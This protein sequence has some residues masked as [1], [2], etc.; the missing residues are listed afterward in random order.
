[1]S[2]QKG[3]DL[4]LNIGDGAA[5]EVYTTVAGLR[6]TTIQFNAKDIDVTNTDSSGMW[7]ELLSGAGIKSAEIGGSGVFK[8]AESDAMLRTVFFDQTL[9]DWQIVIPGF[10]TISGPFKISRLQYEGQFDDEV[11]LTIALSSAGAL[12]FAAST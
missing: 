3:K 4:L 2:A 12:N 11:R 7:R 9:P 10:G 8:D 5:N 1:M 6:S